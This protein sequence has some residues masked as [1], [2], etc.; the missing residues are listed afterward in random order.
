M[1]MR[2]SIAGLTA[3]AL[4]SMT[5]FSPAL[6]TRAMAAQNA[7]TSPTTGTVSGL[8]ITNNYNAALDS[9]NTANSGATARQ[10]ATMG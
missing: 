1:K 9:L 3:F 8:Q 6:E 2:R 7:L 10:F 4:Y 5:I